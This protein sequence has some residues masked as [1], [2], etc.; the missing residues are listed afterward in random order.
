MRRRIDQTDRTT[1]VLSHFSTRAR[2]AWDITAGCDCPISQKC[3]APVVILSVTCNTW[4]S[5]SETITS[6]LISFPT[7]YSSRRMSPD[8]PACDDSCA[9]SKYSEV[10][11]IK[12]IP[13]LPE[14]S[15]GLQ[16]SG[17]DN[18]GCACAIS[19]LTIYWNFG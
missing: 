13:R 10:F 3:G 6:T 11:P 9:F 17:K 1:S 2:K 19:S 16:I 4:G 18:C 5:P 12:L 15:T 14:L 7:R 8:F